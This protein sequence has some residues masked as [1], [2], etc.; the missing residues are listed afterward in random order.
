ML[1]I[2][3]ANSVLAQSREG[4]GRDSPGLKKEYCL[5]NL[6]NVSYNETTCNSSEDCYSFCLF[7]PKDYFTA[8]PKPVAG[9]ESVCKDCVGHCS[10]PPH[11]Y[12]LPCGIGGQLENG[13]LKILPKC[14]DNKN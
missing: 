10:I 8:D 5:Y 4:I 7:I 14:S 9:T 6:Q 11:D 2:I 12:D 3:P 13:I 1:L